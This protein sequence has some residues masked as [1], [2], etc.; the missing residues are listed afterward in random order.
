[1]QSAI[2]FAKQQSA[3]LFRL[4]AAIS[5]T[6]ADNEYLSPLKEA[7]GAFTAEADCPELISARQILAQHS[8]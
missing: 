3:L 2:A 5:L 8:G 6:R 1:F 4:R 7:V